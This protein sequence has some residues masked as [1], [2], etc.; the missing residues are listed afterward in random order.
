L[1][2][3]FRYGTFKAPAVLQKI[4]KTPKVIDM[5]GPLAK[6]ISR[7]SSDVKVE[8]AVF[9]PAS[10]SAMPR[11]RENFP[12]Y[13]EETLPCVLY[14]CD[15]SLQLTYVS[16]N[17]SE[18]LGIDSSELIGNRLLSNERIPVEDLVLVA[19]RLDELGQPH[20]RTSLV[21]RILDSRGL[22]FW[23]AHSL[24][25]ASLGDTTVVR[26]CIVPM[27]YSGRL[28][29]SEQAVISRF[30]HKIGNHFQLLNLVVN[31]LKRTLPESRET[32][33]LEE[34][35]EKAIELTRGFSDY[36]QVPTCLS[37]VELNEILQAAVMTRRSSFEKKGITFD[38]QLHASTSGIAIQADPYLLELAIGH[39]LQNALEATEAGGQV[40]LQARLTCCGD[41]AVAASIS[42]IDSGCG[43]DEDALTNVVVPFFTSKKNHDGLGLS[44]AS[45]FIEIH[46]GILRITSA[47]GKGTEVEIVLPLQAER[48]SCLQ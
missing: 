3:H 27:D 31:S 6:L 24:W 16:N 40:T 8:D 30:V 13:F 33:M 28:N 10:P 2:H 17:I 22:P 39:I 29:S 18:L 46:G 47:Q 15:A 38:S 42:V 32:L 4:M 19:N 7:Q 23:V 11:R 20:R 1:T 43:I 44:M 45:R 41:R 9:E 26:G 14:E 37:R 5:P 36:N 48:E 25:K 35:V 21:H 12:A 34:T